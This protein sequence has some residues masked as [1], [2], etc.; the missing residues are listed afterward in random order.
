MSTER[1]LLTA[2]LLLAVMVPAAQAIPGAAP[3][4]TGTSHVPLVAAQGDRISLTAKVAG[5]GKPVLIGLV[6]GNQTWQWDLT[7]A[8]PA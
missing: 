7:P 6:L 1:P 8:P 2:A 4:I 3:R 5:T